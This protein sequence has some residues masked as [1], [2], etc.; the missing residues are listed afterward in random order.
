MACRLPRLRELCTLTVYTCR[1]QSAKYSLG[2]RHRAIPEDVGNFAA[3]TSDSSLPLAPTEE[4]HGTEV[5]S[6]KW[7]FG[8]VVPLT[9]TGR[10]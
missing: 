2:C 1:V 8:H 7:Q 4:A 6:K 5:R 10:P 9:V 3:L